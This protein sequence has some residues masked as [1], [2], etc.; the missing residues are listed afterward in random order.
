M[1]RY[2][3]KRGKLRNNAVNFASQNRTSFESW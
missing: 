3:R 2:L 1:T